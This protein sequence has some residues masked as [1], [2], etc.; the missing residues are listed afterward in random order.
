LEELP[1]FKV[2]DRVRCIN[3]IDN[4]FKITGIT[5]NYYICENDFRIYF[6]FQENW[7]LVKDITPIFK[8]GDKIR[9]KNDKT[10]VKI[11]DYIYSDSYALLDGHLLYFNEQDQYELV[12]NKFKVGDSVRHVSGS[13]E[14]K[15]VKVCDKGYCI[16]AKGKGICY[17]SF[18]LEKDYELVNKF[19]ISKL[20]PFDKVL[21]RADNKHVWSIQFF[22]RLNTKLKDSFVCMGGYRY[23]QC[24]PYE[25]NEHLLNTT[26]DCDNCFKVWEK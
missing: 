10:I 11:I 5:N 21:V 12:S 6:K 8:I 20:K 25:G 9:P 23:R 13:R 24:I 3:N 14:G 2:G 17:I 16:D 15:I 26:N 1:K 7:E 18:I 4:K 19:D 22:E